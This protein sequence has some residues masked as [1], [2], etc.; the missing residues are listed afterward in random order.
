MP[1]GAFSISTSNRHPD[2]NIL[3]IAPNYVGRHERT[4]FQLHNRKDVGRRENFVG[5]PIP[6]S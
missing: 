5:M 2:T 6:R 3:G 4:F 1:F